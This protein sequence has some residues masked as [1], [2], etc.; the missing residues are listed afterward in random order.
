MLTAPWVDMQVKASVSGTRAAMSGA[1]LSVL[2]LVVANP[3]DWGAL[4]PG[5]W[6][7]LD[8][9]PAP[10]AADHGGAPPRPAGVGSAGQEEDA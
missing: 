9:I 1:A 10:T 4:D 6:S 5:A 8:G 7:E 3:G 2:R